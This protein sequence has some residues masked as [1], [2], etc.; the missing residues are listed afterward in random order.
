M[1]KKIDHAV[2]DY[3]FEKVPVTKAC[4]FHVFCAGHDNDIF[5]K[6]DTLEIDFTNKEYEFLLAFKA[7]A[8]SLWRVQFLL[9]I[10]SQVALV[11]PIL[12]SE[13]NPDL[14]N[15]IINFDHLKEQYERFVTTYEV[16][17]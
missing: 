8:F 15:V 1:Y 11:R 7:I 10:D 6:V 13:R 16:Y 17:V 9:G 14:K 4:A 3:S 5:E 12:I 2:N